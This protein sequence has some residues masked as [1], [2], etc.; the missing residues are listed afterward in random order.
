MP[1]KAVVLREVG[2]RPGP[3]YTRIHSGR[4]DVHSYGET[5]EEASKVRYAVH[6]VLKGLN[7]EVANATLLHR[8]SPE[9]AAVWLLDPETD[10]PLFVS[11]WSLLASEVATA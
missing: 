1:R 11:S 3:D 6:E 2:G 7:R 8:A 10:W 9:M 5:A 4:V